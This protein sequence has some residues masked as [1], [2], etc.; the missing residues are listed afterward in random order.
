VR[1]FTAPSGFPE[2]A[3]ARRGVDLPAVITER[4]RDGR[5]V[6]R[7]RDLRHEQDRVRERQRE[8]SEQLHGED[9]RPGLSP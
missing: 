8:H 3:A 9:D 7:N 2:I 5:E 6:A 4:R 1:F